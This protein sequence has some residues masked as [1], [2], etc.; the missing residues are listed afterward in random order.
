MTQKYHIDGT[1]KFGYIT[2][3]RFLYSFYMYMNTVKRITSLYR[4]ASVNYLKGYVAHFCYLRLRSFDTFI[5]VVLEHKD[6]VS[7]NCLLRMLGDCVA[8]FRLVYR[9]PDKDLLILR[10]CL[11]VIDGCERNLEVLPEKNI[12]EDCLPEEE[13]AELKKATQVNRAQRQRMIREAQEMLEA[14]PLK[15][16][17]KAA[18]D[19]IVKDRN[20]K[21]KE[22]K[23]YTKKGSNQYQWRELYERID[24]C[25]GFD[26]LSYISQYAHGLSMSNLVIE[27][28]EQNIDGIV[29][30]AVGLIKRLHKYT[31]AFYPEEQK[32]ILEGLLEPDMRD[33]IL[34]CYD[35]KHRP[36]IATWKQDIMNK[37][38]QL[39]D[40]GY[41]EIIY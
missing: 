22:F 11:Y 35:D 27:L 38:Y 14:S 7:A 2:I 31:M 19:R 28:D 17:D 39:R 30:E 8:V 1:E 37:L 25:K 29:S 9:E 4:Y 6:Y 34:A 26:L 18:F 3:N 24:C 20:W 13:L 41:Y 32:Y 10:H 16:K 5:K 15:Q 33:K 36:D 21:F 40:S 12:N 23:D